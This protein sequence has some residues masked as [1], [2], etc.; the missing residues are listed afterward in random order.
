[1]GGG[2]GEQISFCS[3]AAWILDNEASFMDGKKSSYAL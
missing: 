2:G 1:M 3:E